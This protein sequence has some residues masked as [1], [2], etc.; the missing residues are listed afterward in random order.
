MNRK[1]LTAT[2]SLLLGLA[3]VAAVALGIAAPQ[4]TA[5]A[6][7]TLLLQENFDYGSTP[8]NL[9]AVS[10]G[11]WVA[12]SGAGSGPVQYI[13][14]GLS[15]PK[16]GSSGIGGAA[17]I[18][19][20]ASEDVWRSFMT[21][22][23][24]AIY[25]AALVRV[26]TAT[27]TGDYFL[28]LMGPEA[29]PSHRARIYVRDTNGNLRFGLGSAG[30]TT[31]TT[32]YYSNDNFSYNTTYLVVAKYDITNRQALLYVLTTAIPNEPGSPLLSMALATYPAVQ[33]VGIRQGTNS[34]AVI[35]DG[36]RVAT[37]WADVIGYGEVSATKSVTPQTDVPYHGT[38][39][40]TIVLRNS[41]AVNDT[42]LFTDTLPAEVDFG[43][44]IERPEGA[45]VDNDVITWSGTITA[46]TAV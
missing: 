32:P 7:S 34:P 26:V 14:A 4:R 17:A 13:T 5:Q 11:N 3:A 29:T 43:Q 19:V 37:T 8:G 15:M 25:Y 35:I 22:T 46:G 1:L 9:T 20:S 40:Y 45:T 12:H 41:R 18:S 36:I 10:G 6:Q 16:Y 30:T 21:Q 24:G 2:L 31:P 39:T 33:G 38:V 23:S 27:T 42:V 28:H 44:W